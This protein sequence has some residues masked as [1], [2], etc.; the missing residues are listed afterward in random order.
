M[1]ASEDHIDA[2]GNNYTLYDINDDGE[3]DIIMRDSNSIYIKYAEQNTITNSDQ[4][5][6]NSQYYVSPVLNDPADLDNLTDNNGYI[7]V[8]AQ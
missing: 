6:Y 3:D 2:I 4:T 8:S 1:V 7:T 5:S